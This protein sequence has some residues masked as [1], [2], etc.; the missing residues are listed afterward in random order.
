MVFPIQCDIDRTGPQAGRLAASLAA[1]I[2]FLRVL[3]LFVSRR[4]GTPLRVLCIMAFDTVHVL[5]TSR[6]LSSRALKILAALLDYG[7]CANDFFDGH[8]FSSQEYQATRRLLDRAAAS[9]SVNEYVRRLRDLERRRPSPGGDAGQHRQAQSYRES[10]IRLS[11]GM[12]AATTLGSLTLEDGI[13]AT[14]RDE[15]LET[16]YRIVMLCQIIDD[17]LDFATDIDRGLPSFLTAHASPPT[18]LA[19]TAEAATR[20]A[21]RRGLPGSPHVFP[22]RLALLGISVLAKVVILCGRWR[23]KLHALQNRFALIADR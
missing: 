18:A 20:Y 5:R 4:P 11:L 2:S 15:D 1:I 8:D 9:V 22:F 23:L 17:F 12:I 3:P 6:R 14:Y 19:L 10:V 7:A 21:D 13:R 16:L